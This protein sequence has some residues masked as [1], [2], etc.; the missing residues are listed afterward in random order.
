MK[1]SK[2]IMGCLA[3]LGLTV[4]AGT[5]MAQDDAEREAIAERLAPVG[6]LC[7]QG[8][9]CG[10]MAAASGGGSSAS[11]GGGGDIDGEGIYNNVCMACHETG[12]AGAPV[13]GNDEQW[14]ARTEKGFATLLDH[15][16]N[17]FNAM[18]AKGGNPNL[19]DAEV[20]AAV[21][22]LV[23]PVMEVPAQGGG[24][25]AA[26]EEASSTETAAS[27][28]ASA[29]EDT[30][31]DSTNESQAAAE[32]AHA[33]IDGAAIY[34]QICMA[35]HETGAAGAPVRGNAEQWSA[36]LEQGVETLYDHSINGFNAMPAKGGN[37]NLSDDEVKAATDYL[38]EPVQ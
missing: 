29:A 3:T 19:S 11:S 13:R 20:E 24:D 8:E 36:R 16:I 31:A 25:A 9:D 28:Q 32:P 10:T 15:A 38:I 23:E 22:Y 6:E 34:N 21:A 33:G 18:P 2:L 17:G 37:P 35:C 5:A 4:G 27:E 30:A 12:A 14:S 1:S 7:V 26:T